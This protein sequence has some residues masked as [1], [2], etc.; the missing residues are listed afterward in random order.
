MR[1]FKIIE[2]ILGIASFPAVILGFY[3]TLIFAP[4]ERTMGDVQRIFYIHLPLAWISFLAFFIVFIAGIMYLIKGKMHWDIIAHASAEIGVIFNILVIVSG[5]IW[6]RATW[7]TWWTWDPR[8][9]T[10]LIL[11]LIYSGY[12]MIRGTE[13][14]VEKKA[15]IS[16]VIGI[17]GFVNVP[18][19]F[20]AIRWWR[21]MH[22]VVITTTSFGLAPPMLITLMVC[23][24]VV[25]LL[26]AYLLVYR[27]RI[28]MAERDL[29]MI[30]IQ[31]ES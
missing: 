17:V 26:F 10:M 7:N 22:P 11:L 15:K 16:A 20:M 3:M 29:K 19:V 12:L 25:T 30:T 13:I 4:T 8:L 5:S 31:L 28:G 23:L 9:T 1:K 2:T 27:I 24:G 14:N 18:I 6:A 21:S